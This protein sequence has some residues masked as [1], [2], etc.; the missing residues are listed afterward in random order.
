MRLWESIFHF[1][2]W[3]LGGDRTDVAC[4]VKLLHGQML[5]ATSN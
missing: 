1:T 4:Y 3:D 5:H 2:F